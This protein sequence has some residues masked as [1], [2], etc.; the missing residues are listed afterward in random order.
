MDMTPAPATVKTSRRRVNTYVVPTAKRRDDLVWQT[1]Q[2]L[3]AKDSDANGVAARV[4]S[5]SKTMVPNFFVPATEKR[6]D[7]LRWAG[8]T[9][10]ALMR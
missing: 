1:R 5:G 2:R 3:Q 7:D 6:R 8:R 9:E 10:M 4:G